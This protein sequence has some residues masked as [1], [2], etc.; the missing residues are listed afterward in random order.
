MPG[1]ERT[2]GSRTLLTSRHVLVAVVIALASRDVGAQA[3]P[4]VAPGAR[5]YSDIDR[6]AGAGLIDTIGY[7]ARPFSQREIVRLLNEARRNLD[8]NARTR[9]WA[10][11]VVDADLA[12][13][14]PH[15]LR[16]IDAA[17]VEVSYMDSP[18]RIVPPDSNGAI[19]ATINPLV[20]DRGGR[21]LAIGTTTNL[22][23][24][25]SVAIG[26]HLALSISPRFTELIGHHGGR[27]DQARVQSG[28]ANLLFGNFAI[29]IGRDYALFSQ[30]PAGGLLLSENAPP[31]DMIRVG[32]DRPAGLPWLLRYLGPL[33][34]TLL[35]ADLG[36][37]NQ[38]HAHS[39]LIG[40]HVEAHPHRFFEFGVEVIDEMGGNGAPPASFGDRVADAFP[41][42]DVAFRPNSDF[43]F[44]NKLA[45]V[46]FHFRAPSLAGLDMYAEGV[47]DDFDTRRFHS[48]IFQDGGGIAGISLTCIAECGRF[49]VRAEYH[50][51]GIRYYTHTQFP[52]GIQE[53]GV[54]LGDPLGPRGLGGYL[55]I[56]GESSRVGTMALAGAY[57]VRSGNRYGAIVGDASDN[58]FRFVQIEHHPGE[59]RARATATWTPT[60]RSARMTIRAT[61]GVE[62]VTNFAF[63]DGRNRT[64]ALAQL[65]YE[66]RP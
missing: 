27:A 55:T 63:V 15:D 22:E 4:R 53:N 50:Q 51:T 20:S 35:V 1:T 56:D 21:P 18:Y 5:V 65:G 61:L 38:V 48:T 37:L 66:W 49:G 28:S 60:P 33:Q 43:L 29:D 11:T 41:V 6:L 47:V 17:H 25:H 2:G 59:H 19:A 12:R 45:G 34:A 7:G 32:T 30:A 39:K 44:S 24:E 62:H 58:G 23:T 31:L 52:S 10:E 3:S 64:N 8:R 13:Y 9:A 57:E 26:S 36:T 40:Y 42:I 14:A 46:D 16:A 54:I